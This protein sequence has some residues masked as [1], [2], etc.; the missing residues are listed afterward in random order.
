MEYSGNKAPKETDG[1]LQ[2]AREEMAKYEALHV[3]LGDVSRSFS[4]RE[5]TASVF[6][7]VDVVE[8]GWT[9][10]ERRNVVI[11][12]QGLSNEELQRR[13]KDANGRVRAKSD[14]F[15]LIY[16]QWQKTQK[17]LEQKTKS[18]ATLQARLVLLE[19]RLQ[20]KDAAIDE[21]RFKLSLAEPA[22]EGNGEE[23]ENG[24]S[25]KPTLARTREHQRSRKSLS[26]RS[27]EANTMVP[28]RR[29]DYHA[30]EW[31]SMQ[32]PP[33]YRISAGVPPAGLL[34]AKDSQEE[35][36]MSTSPSSKRGFFAGF[37]KFRGGNHKNDEDK[38]AC[39]EVPT[40][41]KYLLAK[42]R[43]SF[44]TTFSL[45]SFRGAGKSSSALSK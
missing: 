30:N 32:T 25:R 22:L 13:L 33:S 5:A 21:L 38:S 24:R 37:Y 9:K 20:D 7:V 26:P 39:T 17:E 4:A 15:D 12:G 45:R 8:T 16:S 42:R 14:A 28:R 41:H 43:A 19:K 44:G 18:E 36:S 29:S 31:K 23:K 6:G 40:N 27:E 2:K 3:E 35:S 1:G 10:A 34:E 11:G